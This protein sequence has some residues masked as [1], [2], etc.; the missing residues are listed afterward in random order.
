MEIK[1]TDVKKLRQKTGAGMV[2]CKNALVKAEGDGVKAERVLK[3]LGLAAAAKRSVSE[4][5]ANI[6][7]VSMP[8]MPIK[9]I[10]SAT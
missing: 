2:D 9:D 10:A 7:S 4:I 8:A 3:E 6:S 5:E 1:A